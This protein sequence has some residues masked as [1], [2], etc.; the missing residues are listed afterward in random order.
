MAQP[1]FGKRN[2]KR[3]E[4]TTD[5]AIKVHSDYVRKAS[6]PSRKPKKTTGSRGAGRHM[7]ILLCAGLRDDRHPRA[8][9]GRIRHSRAQPVGGKLGLMGQSRVVPRCLASLVNFLTTM[10]RLSFEIWSM[11]KTPLR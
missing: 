6:P 11:N 9:C 5:K 7:D 1:G 10:S 4:L 8:R 3:I 2:A